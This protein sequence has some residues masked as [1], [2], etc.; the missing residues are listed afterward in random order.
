MTDT[1]DQPFRPTIRH[2]CTM[3]FA[4]FVGPHPRQLYCEACSESQDLKRKR[5]DTMRK[6]VSR[7]KDERRVKGLE[8]SARH[9]RGMA[10]P[11]YWPLLAWQLR[12]SVPFS[13][14]GSKNA[15][16][17]L[18]PKG[19]V[20]LRR[21]SRSYRDALILSLQAGLR[22]RKIVHNKLWIYIFVEKNNHRG[23][24]VNFVD[25]VCDAVK[26]A[27]Q[28][29]DR[30]FC[31]RGVDWSVSKN[32]PNLFVTIGQEQVEDSQICSYCGRLLELSKFAANRHVPT[33]ASRICR[34]CTEK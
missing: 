5:L 2:R 27:T 8:I 12:V 6:C 30:W 20:A 1:F 25:M 4:D 10:D 15:I 23:D 21:E 14:S 18:R 16:Y 7:R 32:D 29:D 22:G 11:P 17:T 9:A 24:A 28:L 3:C 26:V 19:H 13:W 34:E 31:I 33:G